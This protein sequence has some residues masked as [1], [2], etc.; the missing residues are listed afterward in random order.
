MFNII[1]SVTI[2]EWKNVVTKV[3]L[4]ILGSAIIWSI[5]L[6]IMGLCV[7]MTESVQKRHP[8]SKSF[9]KDQACIVSYFLYNL[10]NIYHLKHDYEKIAPLINNAFSNYTMMML[11]ITSTNTENGICGSIQP[12]MS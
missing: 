4:T 9:L 2:N 7:C 6:V 11:S 8:K 5:E 10:K 1:K 12:N 3:I